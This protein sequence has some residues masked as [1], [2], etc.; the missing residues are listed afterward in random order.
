MKIYNIHAAKTHLSALLE[1]ASAGEE[2][3][4]AR[5]GKPVARLVPF[6][7]KGKPRVL[8]ALKGKKI[9]FVGDG[10]NDAPALAQA[11]LGI[12]M[13]SGTDIAIEAGDIVLMRGEPYD[14][15]NALKL[16]KATMDKI[17]QGMFWALIYNV[18][19]IPIAAGLL[20]P[21][22]GWLLSPIFAGGAMALSSVSVVTN[23]LLLRRIKLKKTASTK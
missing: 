15:V 8:G 13:G 2:V 21:F 11:D 6:A 18:I 17:K 23:A 9:A 7:G 19:G 12:A 10:I 3:I 5:A 20:Y 4:I 16:G 1:K 14:V 22:T